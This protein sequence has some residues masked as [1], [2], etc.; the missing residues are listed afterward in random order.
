MKSPSNRSRS[1]LDPLR[2]FVQVWS[3]I[4]PTLNVRIDK[5]TRKAVSEKGDRLM[6]ISPVGRC[7]IDAA[8][9][10]AETVEVTAFSLGLEHTPALEHALAAGAKQAIA[11]MGSDNSYLTLTPLALANWIKTNK[12]D[13]LIADRMAGLVAYHLGWAHLAGIDELQIKEG[14]LR[15]VRLLEQGDREKVYAPLPAAIRVQ[16]KILTPSYICRARVEKVSK[17]QIQTQKLAEKEAKTCIEMGP[18]QLARPRTKLANQRTLSGKTS[19]MDRLNALMGVTST[20]S[21]SPS[22][23][24]SPKKA[25]TP[26]EMA[27]EFVRY[28]RHH[29]LL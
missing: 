14:K 6:R 7:G 16:Q 25:L 17:D 19:G 2:V 9:K 4:D 18:L 12:V 26:P 23:S 5:N 1:R 3:E 29:Q 13:L 28:L 20:T 10:L 22:S 21:K 24:P 27:E 15:C 8:L 11:L